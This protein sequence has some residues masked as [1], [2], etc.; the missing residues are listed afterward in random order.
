MEDAARKQDPA[1]GAALLD[2]LK[3]R[4]G[5]AHVRTG[6]GSAGR[7]LPPGRQAPRLTAVSPCSTEDVQSVVN[8]AREHGASILTC[9]DHA[10]LPEDL[11]R[12]A[13]LLDFSRMNR[14][15]RIDDRNLVAHIERGVTWGQL[16][17]EL[18]KRGVKTVA[19]V[20]ANSASVLESIVARAP[21]KNI[22]KYPDYALTNMKVVL[23]DGEVLKTGTHGLSEDS[24][25][26]RPEGGPNLSQW[27]VGAD[28][29]FGIVVRA[30]VMLWPVCEARSAC[31]HGFED[32][33]ELLR[34]LRDIPRTDLGCEFLGINR[35]RMEQLLG[36]QA[37]PFPVWSLAVGFE[38]RESLVAHNQDRVRGLLERY[39][40]Q[41]LPALGE[42]VA[43]T[44][45]EPWMEASGSH[46]AFFARFSRLPDL[47]RRME[48]AAAAAGV[49]E[50]R[51]GKV[52][53]SLD[54]GRAV[55]AVYDWFGDGT[56]G[57]A[58]SEANLEMAGQ[59]AFFDRP[60]GA[61]GRK[62]YESIPNHLPV[63]QR[64]KHFMDPDRV[65]NPGRTV[66]DHDRPWSPPQVRAGETGLTVHNLKEVKDR[67]GRALGAEWV[68]DNPADLS[69]YG[70][71]FTVFSGE[72]PNLVVLPA[73][74]E[75]VREV[76]RIAY[77]H[78][79]P[80]VP[81]TTGFNHGGLTVPRKGG[82]LVD[83]RRM[84]GLC[85][86]DEETMTITVS[87]AVRMR[88][89]WWEASR[90]D[91]LPGYGL[92]PILPLTMG[93]VSLLSNYVAR[94]APASIFKYGSATELTAHM[95]WVL[96]NGDM[97]NLGPA[98]VPGVGPLPLHY[99]P[100]P[101]INGMFFNADGQF[102]ICTELTAKLYPE[103]RDAGKMEA[104]VLAS[105]TE[106]D[107]TRAL[108]R[109]VDAFYALAREN[110]TEFQYKAHPGTFALAISM[111]VEG[112]QIMDMVD[113]SPRHPVGIIVVGYD[114]DEL[115]IKQE[116]LR[117][118]VEAHDMF[119]IDTSLFLAELAESLTPELTRMSLGV[120]D[121]F[122]GTY[123]GAFQWTAGGLKM[124]R[125]PAVAREYDKLVNK[126]WKTSDPKL[127]V[128]H[129]MTDLAIQGPAPMG[130][131]G[132]CE[133]DYWWDQGNP[134]D[135][136]RATQMIHKTNKLILKHGGW[137]WRNMFGSGE[138]HLPLW[139]KYFEILKRAKRAF[140]PANLMH[141]DVLPLTDDYL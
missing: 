22:S 89:A 99:G 86:I 4:I 3:A 117:Q 27:H 28:D 66:R 124:D 45:D 58:L 12:E 138:Y 31:V 63:L 83:L 136:K 34:A 2:A 80:L 6:P 122:V 93:S 65:L 48:Q 50:A 106:R 123:K 79:V 10:L 82:I 92:K 107:E 64:I 100:G 71:D 115:R 91:A 141:P 8:A 128:I 13:V 43:R 85:A 105:S 53:V 125:L 84:D 119:I 57:Q 75:E 15:E 96:P 51:A 129:A 116:I 121:N 140:D 90:R 102:G 39:A 109:I 77:E 56:C 42:A 127:S 11:E 73:S 114:A 88:T 118:V 60:R 69:A 94:G 108:R 134:E 49:P 25:D 67:L 41:P 23:A 18:R 97:L 103:R 62:I 72:R 52:L 135:V 120:K 137:L 87:P 30:S 78:G 68:S 46:T 17:P 76:V 19:P 61:L 16:N 55:Y 36:P 38:G 81:Q 35:A 54:R 33:E 126:Y 1:V 20:A 110:I 5:A 130:R 47:D 21:G 32:I 98:A 24:C 74:T 139:G 40:C 7:L 101:E 95:T 44:L 111:K 113:I 9:N 132:P 131:A 70:R 37:G 112:T 29:I 14:I 104:L 133:F 59:G 26:G